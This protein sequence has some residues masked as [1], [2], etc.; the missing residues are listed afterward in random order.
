[1]YLYSTKKFFFIFLVSVPK[2]TSYVGARY[3][4]VIYHRRNSTENDPGL[5][6]TVC[7]DVTNNKK[8]HPS[9]KSQLGFLD[10]LY[11]AEYTG[12]KDIV[13]LQMSLPGR[14]FEHFDKEVC[15]IIITLNG[16]I[17]LMKCF[18]S[19]YSTVDE[20]LD[21]LKTKF[22]PDHQT[23]VVLSPELSFVGEG[24]TAVSYLVD[25]Q[26]NYD[27]LLDFV[28]WSEG[29]Y[30]YAYLHYEFRH[31]I[32]HNQA[33]FFLPV[34][35]CLSLVNPAMDQLTGLLRSEPPTPPYP[36]LIKYCSKEPT[37]PAVSSPAAAVQAAVQQSSKSS[38]SSPRP[39]KSS[40]GS[41]SSRS[42]HESPPRKKNR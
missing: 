3:E 10:K 34:D 26:K 40:N 42:R 16:Y 38:S 21:L 14:H 8:L 27:L 18:R 20:N 39:A 11:D 7:K 22:V 31:P 32:I 6:A 4:S 17:Q 35:V 2:L 13:F 9:F 19:L 23:L 29:D 1:M 15:G 5:C 30:K 33:P 36:F 24:Y 12:V 28:W 41:S 37:Q 25:S